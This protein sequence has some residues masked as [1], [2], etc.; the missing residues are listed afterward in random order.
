M[1]EILKNFV[2]HLFQSVF[3]VFSF[4]NSFSASK[5]F[6]LFEVI[7]L[8]RLDSSASKSVFVTKFAGANLAL[9]TLVAKV[10]NSGVVIYL[11]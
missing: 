10:L 6:D 5:C 8:L 2:Y 11:S 7:F 9:K 1:A 3:Y 4:F